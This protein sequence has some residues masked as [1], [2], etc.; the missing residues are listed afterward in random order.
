[1]ATLPKLLAR[2]WLPGP[3]C[4][5]WRSSSMTEVEARNL[6]EAARGVERRAQETGE[7]EEIPTEDCDLAFVVSRR[8]PDPRQPDRTSPGYL[9]ILIP[10]K[11]AYLRECVT[12]RL[13]AMVLPGEAGAG[14]GWEFVDPGAAPVEV[15]PRRSKRLIAPRSP[16]ASREGLPRVMCVLFL[17]VAA[18]SLGFILGRL[19]SSGPRELAGGPA[20]Q[21]NELESEWVK[22]R[23]QIAELLQQPFAMRILGHSGRAS[24]AAGTTTDRQLLEDFARLFRR[25]SLDL[26]AQDRRD[27]DRLNES[28]H[29]FFA[30]LNR[31]P[32]DDLSLRSGDAPLSAS[33]ALDT[34]KRLSDDTKRG[35]DLEL[36]FDGT[37]AIAQKIGLALNYENFF[38]NW[39]REHPSARFN[40]PLDRDGESKLL[41]RWVAG[42]RKVIQPYCHSDAN[43][44]R[45]PIAKKKGESPAPAG[46]RLSPDSSAPG[47]KDGR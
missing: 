25:P 45:S 38:R 5:H 4:S 6:I 11:D 28:D 44:S 12:D 42:V 39:S 36:D 47:P 18:A 35:L 37:P 23:W 16:R 10:D 7:I 40:D 34:V 9:I 26:S 13:R 30:F 32:V 1:M 24:N 8:S 46:G 33:E 20:V 21:Q 29:P 17:V 3:G 22:V 27:Y 31:L 19:G 43:N 2:V 14:K 41:T 15:A